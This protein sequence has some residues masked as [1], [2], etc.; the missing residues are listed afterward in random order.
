MYHRVAEMALDPHHL[1]VPP[2]Q[3]RAEM[4]LLAARFR[5]LALEELAAAARADEL[6][7]GAVAVTFDDGCLDNLVNASPILAQI[8]V[9]ATFFV[10]SGAL[11]GG[12][13]P[14]DVLP[15]IF[16]AGAA[17]PERLELPGLDGAAIPTRSA[18]E[19]VEAHWRV[20]ALF[21]GLDAPAR[22]ALLASLAAWSG[23]DLAPRPSHR[24]MTSDELRELASRPGHSIGGHTTNHLALDLQPVAVQSR[25]IAEDREALERLLGRPVTSFAYPYGAHS[26]DTIRLAGEAGYRV[27]VTV[28]PRVVRAGLRPLQVPRLEVRRGP[29]VRFESLLESVARAV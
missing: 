2:K 10:S 25:E 14:W 21:Y 24:T 26:R 18:E 27:A 11:A 15:R 19:R 28:E 22:R 29:L 20:D 12:E 9:P 3:F 5:P 6:P 7:P 13:L 16:L 17:I 23:L 4:E 1:A 8:G